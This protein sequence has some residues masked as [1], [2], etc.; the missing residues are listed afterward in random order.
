VTQKLQWR[1]LPVAQVHLAF[2]EIPQLCQE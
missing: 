1:E 2:W